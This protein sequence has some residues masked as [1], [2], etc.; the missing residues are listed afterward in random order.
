[1][2]SSYIADG[3]QHNGRPKPME[4]MTCMESLPGGLRGSV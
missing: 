2:M 4:T 1:M 3:I